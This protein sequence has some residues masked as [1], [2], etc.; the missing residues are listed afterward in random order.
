MASKVASSK[1]HLDCIAKN[2]IV[3]ALDSDELLKVSDCISAKEM[4]D[5]LERIHKNSRS[6]CMDKNE[7]SAE[8]SSPEF[9]MEVCLMATK[10]SGSN[11]LS[12]Y[13][14]NNCE[15]YF[16][17]LNVFQETHL[18]AK[19]LTLSNYRLKSEKNWLKEKFKVLEKDLNNSNADFENLEMIY[20]N[21]SCKC[22]S[23]ICKNCESFQKKVLY[24]VKTVDTI[25]KGKSNFE[26]VLASQK[27]V[28]G[29]SG[30]G[31]NPQSKTSGCTK[32]FSTITKNQ[33]VKRLKQT[34]VYCFYCMRKGHSVRFCKIR[35]FFVPKGILMWVPKNHKV[36]WNHINIHGPKFVRGP[37]LTT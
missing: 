21:F 26:N 35:K 15:K 5:T 34:V 23:S 22:D 17:L 9:K 18:E 30:L 8:S 16:Q 4:W 28:F 6:A 32:P 27:C 7:P 3:S 10:E 33:S 31:F 1:T 25:S 14:S 11:Q 29:K 37:D 13:S 19:R 12:T 2:I 24:L 36:P 20:Q